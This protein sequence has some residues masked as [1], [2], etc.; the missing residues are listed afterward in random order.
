MSR[1]VSDSQCAR[2]DRM[3]RAQPARAVHS[4]SVVVNQRKSMFS[5]ERLLSLLSGAELLGQR[6]D[7]ALGAA[8]V[9]EQVF[10]LVLR[11]LAH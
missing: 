9:T 1:W 3:A 2:I 8:D 11:H 4:P 10:V 6:D 5:G 7:D